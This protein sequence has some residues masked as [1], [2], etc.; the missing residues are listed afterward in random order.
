MPFTAAEVYGTRE[1]KQPSGSTS[2]S[3]SKEGEP[4]GRTPAADM[5]GDPIFVL[6]LVLGVALL[7]GWL[8]VNIRI[9]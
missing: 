5:D 6:V 2:P 8:S 7:F 4:V 1:H 3:S 9:G